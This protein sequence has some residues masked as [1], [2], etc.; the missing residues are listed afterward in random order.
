MA[1]FTIH[2]FKLL[3]SPALVEKIF[4]VDANPG[5][6]GI[7]AASGS[8]RFDQFAQ[9]ASDYVDAF[10][11]VQGI[12]IPVANPNGFIKRC[13][14]YR[15]AVDVLAFMDEPISDDIKETASRNESILYDIATGKLSPPNVDTRVDAG[16]GGSSFSDTEGNLGAVF[17]KRKMNGT[18]F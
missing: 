16:V 10:L 14:L 1:Y 4:G 9:Q 12:E 13:A 7:S 11:Q 18:F 15:C 3:L 6:G 8:M 17:T 5:W 2:E